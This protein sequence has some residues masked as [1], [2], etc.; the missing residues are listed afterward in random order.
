MS[1]SKIC[2]H[3]R[4]SFIFFFIFHTDKKHNGNIVDVNIMN[5]IEIPSIV[6]VFPN[7]ST[8]EKTLSVEKYVL[9]E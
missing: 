6:N 4:S 3:I 9:L 7:V 1:T 8:L 5:S 2:R